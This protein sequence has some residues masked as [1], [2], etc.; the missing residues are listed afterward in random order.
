MPPIGTLKPPTDI[1]DS[2]TSIGDCFLKDL[3]PIRLFKDNSAKNDIS[4]KT[5]KKYEI[6]ETSAFCEKTAISSNIKLGEYCYGL[7]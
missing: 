7:E 1:T 2:K 6:S 3:A 5:V 4:Y